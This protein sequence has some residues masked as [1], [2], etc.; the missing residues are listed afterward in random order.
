MENSTPLFQA[1]VEPMQV[2]ALPEE[3]E[4]VQ[5]E[6]HIVENTN[7]VSGLIINILILRFHD[8]T[9]SAY[10]TSVH[11]FFPNRMDL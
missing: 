3:N 4:N 5:V 2:D 9:F 6:N 11:Y 1:A 8:V 7:L 10:E